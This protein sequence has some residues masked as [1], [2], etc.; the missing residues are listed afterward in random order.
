[1]G[2]SNWLDRIFPA[3]DTRAAP[4]KHK[5]TLN[6]PQQDYEQR[7]RK[8][9]KGYVR[10]RIGRF[11]RLVKRTR[12]RVRKI[13]STIKRNQRE[14]RAWK[15]REAQEQARKSRPKRRRVKRVARVASVRMR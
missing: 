12:R 8:T 13:N 6:S 14:I 1:M 7:Q 9:K 10:V 4:L 2:L 3:S 15:R 5:P 11:W